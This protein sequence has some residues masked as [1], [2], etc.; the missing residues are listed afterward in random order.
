MSLITKA[1][2]GD[3]GSDDKETTIIMEGPLSEVLYR[4][5]N[6][7][8]A[9]KGSEALNDLSL[10]TLVTQSNL[11]LEKHNHTPNEPNDGAPEYV[12]FSINRLEI[13][14][15][16]IVQVKNI[17]EKN[18]SPNP[19]I[20]FTNKDSDFSSSESDTAIVEHK[21]ENSEKMAQ[22]LESYALEH[23]AVI[24]HYPVDLLNIILR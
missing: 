24:V 13:E 5:L 22:A 9:K 4:E 15:Q 20:L 11:I 21:S 23:G 16:N 7:V 10:E 2:K 14:P 6:S 18:T 17:I 12:V 3:P 19:V 8:Y 1:I